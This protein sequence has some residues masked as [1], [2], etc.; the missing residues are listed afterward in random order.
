M[1]STI[2]EDFHIIHI[3]LFSPFISTSQSSFPFRY[4]PPEIY[5]FGGSSWSCGLSFVKNQ[6]EG[7]QGGQDE[8]KEIKAARHNGGVEEVDTVEK[9]KRV[10]LEMKN[11]QDIFT[12]DFFYVNNRATLFVQI[13]SLISKG[14]PQIHV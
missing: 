6:I 8:G 14:L 5:V 2:I 13:V 9:E 4:P 3:H 1:T 12:G 11:R 10:G 7:G